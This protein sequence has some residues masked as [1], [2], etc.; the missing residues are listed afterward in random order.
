MI[1]EYL[2][3]GLSVIPI[4]P[5]AKYPSVKWDEYQ[6]RIATHEE[7]SRWNIPIGIVCGKISGGLVCIDFDDHGS[8]FNDWI[9]LVQAWNVD[10]ALALVIQQTPSGG[11][12]AIYRCEASAI[13]NE[14]LARM[15]KP[16][17]DGKIDL[18]ET[19]G[20]G[21]QFLAYPSDGYKLLQNDF[22]HIPVVKKESHEFLIQC[23]RSFNKKTNDIEDKKIATVNG[24][25]LSPFDAY[26]KTNTPID[27]LVS[28]GWTVEFER[29]GVVYLKRPG[30]KEKG[31]S[32]SWNH[33]PDRFYVFSTNTEF[34]NEHIYKASSVYAK[35]EHNGN[36]SAAARA[37]LERGFGNKKK[38]PT[39]TIGNVDG[40][41]SSDIR[42]FR[43][44]GD[45]WVKLMNRK[46]NTDFG[47]KSL[48]ITA[49]QFS[50]GEV[51]TI[52]ARSGVG[53]TT[54]GMTLLRNITKSE[55][56]YGMFFSL[57]M[58]G[59]M[60]FQRGGMISLAGISSYSFEANRT[61]RIM[62]I[63]MNDFDREKIIEDFSLILTV[64]KA[65]VSLDAMSNYMDIARKKYGEIDIV[66]IDYLGYIYDGNPGSSYE[67][68]SRIAKGAKEFAKEKSTR[69][70]LLAQTSRAG[71]DGF[72]PVRLN[73]LRDSGA[74]EESADYLLGMWASRAEENRIHCEMLKNKWHARGSKF[75]MIN[76]NLSFTETDNV[77]EEIEKKKY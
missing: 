17:V 23:A 25:E 19:R 50:P 42:T 7:A 12:H 64:D 9:N 60:I 48:N 41:D 8:K 54:M 32:A 76:S 28:H 31:I 27:V 20:E 3:N 5:G 30:K 67:K 36:Y 13:G 61:D 66:A 11:Y 69:V 40:L 26:D 55:N 68:A 37:L 15:D 2:K 59:E 71:E 4:T 14:K 58:S 38:L 1:L 16:N 22:L 46:S 49:K 43:E 21:G 77:I 63:M 18:I 51:F 73:H 10:L 75:D 44:L 72:E 52:A 62:G 33:I 70:V 65:K 35:L 24:F 39:S 56:R 57:E 47:M 34:E 6:N 74:V 53:K 29:A 45:G